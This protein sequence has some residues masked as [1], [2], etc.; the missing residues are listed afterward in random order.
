MRKAFQGRE[1][2]EI[3]IQWWEYSYKL[4]IWHL[5]IICRY[6]VHNKGCRNIFGGSL[7]PPTYLCNLRLGLQTIPLSYDIKN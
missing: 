5:Y 2:I 1:N 4:K 3:S 6:M 7:G